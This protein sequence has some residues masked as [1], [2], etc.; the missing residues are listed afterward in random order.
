VRRSEIERRIVKRGWL[1]RQPAGFRRRLL[2]VGHVVRIGAGS[3]LFHAG[4]E[5]GGAY[6]VVSGGIGAFIPVA[7]GQLSLAHILRTGMWFGHGP[8][9]TRER[10]ILSFAATEP[11]LLLHVALAE[12]DRIM[13]EDPLHARSV[14]MIAD[15]GAAMAISAMA[16]L[17]VRRADRRV[18]AALLRATCGRDLA[19]PEPD[20]DYQLTQAQLGEM[21]N[22]SRDLVNRTLTR[23][24]EAEMIAVGYGRIA[25]RDPARIAAFVRGETD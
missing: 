9:F 4:D 1:S 17:L 6:G 16:D 14:G 20:V 23:L 5:R 10:R 8:L 25:I 18:A 2:S 7:D 3:G 11:S 13:A 24:A 22:A 19:A 15:F 12:L 21:A